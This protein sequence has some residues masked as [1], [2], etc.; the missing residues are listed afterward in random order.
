MRRISGE[1]PFPE[2]EMDGSIHL[3]ASP[4]GP[5]MGFGT[6]R[7]TGNRIHPAKT[8]NAFRGHVIRTY[9]VC[10]QYIHIS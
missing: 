3:N 6:S 2:R 4:F 7:E 1:V 10:F 5:T 9:S 8:T